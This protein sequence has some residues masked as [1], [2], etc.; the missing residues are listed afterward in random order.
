M[1]DVISALVEKVLERG[2]REREEGGYFKRGIVKW[3]FRFE[4]SSLFYF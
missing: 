3:R 2:R 1:I 4:R